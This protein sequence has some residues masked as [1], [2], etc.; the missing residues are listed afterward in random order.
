VLHQQEGVSQTFGV[1][2]YET[3]TGTP[4][5]W[6]KV[7]SSRHATP[8]LTQIDHLLQLSTKPLD[9]VGVFFTINTHEESSHCNGAANR[10]F[11]FLFIGRSPLFGIKNVDMD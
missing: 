11:G 7:A 4:A 1:K 8:A 10:Q 3:L 2:E 6:G 9:L 5:S